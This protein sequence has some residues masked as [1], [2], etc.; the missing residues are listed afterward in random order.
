MNNWHQINTSENNPLAGG[1]YAV[2]Y[3]MN[4]VVKRFIADYSVADGWLIGMRGV[5]ILA[6]AELPEIPNEMRIEAK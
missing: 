5:D 2:I 6:W 3:R 4:S 1:R